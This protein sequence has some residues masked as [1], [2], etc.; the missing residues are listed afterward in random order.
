MVTEIYNHEDIYD[1]EISPLMK[2]IIDICNTHKIPMMCSFAYKNTNDIGFY[3]CD[4]I[5]NSYENRMVQ[6]FHDAYSLLY[7]RRR[8]AFGLTITK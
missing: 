7:N 1:K 2:Q 5:L 4:T 6:D 8:S 3:C